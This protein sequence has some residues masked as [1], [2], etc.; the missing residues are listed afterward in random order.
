MHLRFVGVD[1]IPSVSYSRSGEGFI[2]M[3]FFSSVTMRK[4]FRCSNAHVLFFCDLLYGSFP[5]AG[6]GKG[7]FFFFQEGSSR[8]CIFFDG[9]IFAGAAGDRVSEELPRGARRV[10]AL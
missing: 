9:Y 6:K 10:S 7:N 5:L 1:R 2:S 4:G 8:F 3:L